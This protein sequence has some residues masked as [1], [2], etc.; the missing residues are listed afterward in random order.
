MVGVNQQAIAN[1]IFRNQQVGGNTEIVSN[2]ASLEYPLLRL[3]KSKHW[4]AVAITLLQDK[5]AEIFKTEEASVSYA[6]H[7]QV[8]K[9]STISLGTRALIQTS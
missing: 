4:S 3:Q 8:K 7:I 1:Y 5:A 6:M 2:S 9:F